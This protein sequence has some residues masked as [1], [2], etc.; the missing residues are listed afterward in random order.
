L[1]AILIGA[2]GLTLLGCSHSPP[3]ATLSACPGTGAAV[4]NGKA[5]GR[6]LNLVTLKPAS[7]KRRL[8]TAHAGP[9]LAAKAAKPSAHAKRGVA[10][11]AAPPKT[12]KAPANL[13][14]AQASVAE[15]QGEGKAT[16][17]A[18]NTN[19]PNTR[20]QIAA[21]TVDAPKEAPNEVPALPSDTDALMAVMMVRPEVK[22]VADLA[23]KTVAIDERYSASSSTVRTAIVA[24]GATEVQLSEG[25]T[26]AMNRLSN[27]EVPA[28][29]VALVTPE[30]AETFPA[31]AGYSIFHVPLSPRSV[32]AAR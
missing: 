25:P 28:A 20:S 6:P 8:A 5:V 3:P 10:A 9:S 7:P 4:C 19:A 21:A 24:A 2:L 29:V 32:K 31:I 13:G 23:G 15:R 14:T 11:A 17:A 27:G 1:R 12:A 30:A 22:S 26:T 18:S 16:S